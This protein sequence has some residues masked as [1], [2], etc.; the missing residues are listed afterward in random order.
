VIKDYRALLSAKDTEVEELYREIGRLTAKLS[1][2]E[3]KIKESEL[4]V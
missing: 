1:W 4:R 3:K 2:A